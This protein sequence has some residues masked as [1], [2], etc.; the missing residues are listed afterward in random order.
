MKAG[1]NIPVAHSF[2]DVFRENNI[3]FTDDILPCIYGVCVCHTSIILAKIRIFFDV[4]TG[5]L[6][7]VTLLRDF[8]LHRYQIF[9]VILQP[10]TINF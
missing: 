9:V 7:K 3:V 8:V 2:D 10:K 5:N 1:V 6:R 4:T